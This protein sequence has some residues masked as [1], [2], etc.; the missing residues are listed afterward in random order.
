MTTATCTSTILWRH[1]N[2]RNAAY[3]ATT[4]VAMSWNVPS[5]KWRT[6]W[7]RVYDR[8]SD[9]W[10]TKLIF[11][12]CEVTSQC[13][14]KIAARLTGGKHHTQTQQ[15]RWNVMYRFLYVVCC[16]ISWLRAY[17]GVGNAVMQ[18]TCH[19]EGTICDFMQACTSINIVETLRKQLRILSKLS[20]IIHTSQKCCDFT[21][22]YIDRKCCDFTHIWDGVMS[23]ACK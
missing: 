8:S 20:D 15:K 16:K 21:Y 6:C 23:C 22:M 11:A 7:W 17:Y 1:C 12:E 14:W 19:V 13:L 5:M 3:L 2:D 4:T 18:N 10:R 9:V